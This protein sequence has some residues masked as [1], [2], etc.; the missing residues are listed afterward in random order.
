MAIA[1]N[2]RFLIGSEAVDHERQSL[3][4]VRG[5][6]RAAAAARQV[7]G[8]GRRERL[9]GLLEPARSEARNRDRG[10]TRSSS[11]DG[12]AAADFDMIDFSSP[13][14]IS[15]RRWRRRRWRSPPRDIA[16]ML[17]D[18]NVPR[19]ELVAPRPRPD[20]GEA[21]RGRGRAERD[22]D[23][24]RLFEDA[25][26][27]DAGQP[28]ACHQRQGRS[29][30]ARGRRGDRRGARLRRDRDDDA[31]LAQRLVERARL[32]RRRAGRPRRARFS[33][34]RAKRRRSCR[35]AWPASPP[36][37]RPSRSTAPSAPSSMA[38]TRHGRR[39]SSPPPMPRAASR[40]AAPRAPAPSS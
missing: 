16:R 20:A 19:T 8:R 6:G 38:T 26:A 32:L 14:I 31:R 11:M 4:P 23:R 30:A 12:V 22:G 34:A 40:C 10:R 13:A 35:S 33:S 5:L 1:S 7:R 25:G 24:L 9:C 37:P 27:Q 18:M 2:V 29:A 3:A 21:R 36:T 17:V 39:P 28:G 15:T